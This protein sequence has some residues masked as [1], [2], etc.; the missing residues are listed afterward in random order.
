MLYLQDD[1]FLLNLVDEHD[2]WTSSRDTS[3]MERDDDMTSVMSRQDMLTVTASLIDT[4]AQ[5]SFHST[6]NGTMVQ[7]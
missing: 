1:S 7:W 4:A 3:N 5:H 2:E 6:Y